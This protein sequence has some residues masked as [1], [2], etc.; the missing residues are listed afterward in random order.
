MAGEW[1]WLGSGR[2]KGLHSR[3]W[4]VLTTARVDG[5]RWQ[6]LERLQHGGL[7]AWDHRQAL[8][9]CRDFDGDGREVDCS[10]ADYV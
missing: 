1:N 10:L 8:S 4:K 5:E 2:V 9:D 7:V 6:G 3:A